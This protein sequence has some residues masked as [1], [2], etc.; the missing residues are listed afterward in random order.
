MAIKELKFKEEDFVGK[1]VSSLSDNPSAEGI[2]ATQLKARFDNIAKVI[3]ALGKYNELIDALVATT[4]DSGAKCIGVSAISGVGGLEVQ[5]VLESLKALIDARIEKADISQVLG[6]TQNKIP[7]EKAVTDAMA[8]AGYG[9]MLKSVYDTNNNGTVDNAEMLGNKPPTY[10]GK[11][12]NEFKFMGVLSG[13]ANFNVI[14]TAAS[15]MWQIANI[16]NPPAGL[17]GYG[18]LFSHTANTYTIQHMIDTSGNEAMRFYQGTSW[19]TW[20]Q[21]MKYFKQLSGADTLNNYNVNA[22]YMLAN[23]TSTGITGFGSY[24]MLR[25]ESYRP[26]SGNPYIKQVV[27]DTN[28]Q[29]WERVFNGTSWTAWKQTLT[30]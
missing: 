28:N 9:D 26:T 27:C 2:S 5:S 7:S 8:N 29:K 3:I 24:G 22:M 17:T 23:V 12:S 10:Y 19:T 4:A 20:Q 1:D 16:T 18:I 11:E 21:P 15:Q 25:V 14:S 30:A 13:N 6:N